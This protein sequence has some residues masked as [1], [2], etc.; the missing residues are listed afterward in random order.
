[1]SSIKVGFQGVSGSFSEQALFNYFPNDVSTFAYELFEDVFVE[2]EK[3]NIDYGVLPLENSST[4]AISDVYDLLNQYNCFIA[5]ESYVKVSH[6]L[7]A[8]KEATLEDIKEVYSHT[9]AFE[10]SKSFLKNYPWRL[11]PYYNTAKSAEYISSLNEKSIAAIGSAKAAEL[12]NLNILANDINCNKFNTTRFIIITKSLK[13]NSSCNKISVVLSTK[14]EAGA[15]YKVLEHFA[16]N[17]INLLKIESRPVKHTPWEY[18]FYID[19]EG[20]LDNPE[21][22]KAIDQMNTDCHHFKLLGNYKAS[23]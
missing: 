22:K 4:G 10:Q 12:Y 15:L 8:V 14:H 3:E 21:I 20:N 9:Q 18:Y 5:G 7:L 19:F 6:N 11:V 17:S 16:K 23:K 1:M 13:A 2:L